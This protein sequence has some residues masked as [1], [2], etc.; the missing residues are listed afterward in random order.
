MDPVPLS[1]IPLAN[2]PFLSKI[3][4]LN[5]ESPLRSRPSAVLHLRASRFVIARPA[6]GLLHT[7]GELHSAPARVEFAI[8]PTRLQLIAPLEVNV[9]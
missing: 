8:R 7:D 5:R 1:N 2:P 9:R 4:G 6:P 3:S